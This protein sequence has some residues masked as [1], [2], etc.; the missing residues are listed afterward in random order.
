MINFDRKKYPIYAS[1]LNQLAKDLTKFYNSKLNRT[2]KVSN[3]LKGKGYDPVTTSDRAFEKF[4][5]AKIKKKFPSHQVI[6][7]EYGSTNSKSDY[8][9]VIDPI[10]GTANYFRGLDECCVSIAL[11]EGNE[12]LIGVVYNFNNNQ[13]FTAVKDHGAFLNNAKINLLDAKINLTKVIWEVQGVKE[14]NNKVQISETSNLNS[15]GSIEK[16]ES[17]V[18]IFLSEIKCFSIIFAPSAVAT[19]GATIPSV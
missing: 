14:V 7:E 6:G 16:A 13:M 5:R 8:T 12:A 18:F 10:D 3:K 15:S 1:F 2:F 19:T 9:W 11:M 4:I 17:R